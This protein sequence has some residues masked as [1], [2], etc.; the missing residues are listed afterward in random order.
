MNDGKISGNNVSGGRGIDPAGGGGVFITNGAYFLKTGG[1]IY[2][3]DADE[4]LQNI[5]SYGANSV[6]LGNSDSPGK[7]S[8]VWP[9]ESL[10]DES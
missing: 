10:D 4:E 2:G 5:D 6:Y 8:T 3:N 7:T 9:E 1:T